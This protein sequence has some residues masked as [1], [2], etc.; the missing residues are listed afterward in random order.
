MKKTAQIRDIIM[1]SLKNEKR[2]DNMV[3]AAKDG[4]KIS[5]IEIAVS[6][7]EKPEYYRVAVYKVYP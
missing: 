3:F 4:Y 6:E 5:S 7:N 1:E 2:L